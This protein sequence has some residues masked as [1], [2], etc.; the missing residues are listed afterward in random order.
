MGCGVGESPDHKA[1][2]GRDKEL[3]VYFM[4]NEKS[5]KDFKQ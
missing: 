2:I 1:F 4:T 5:L 3:G